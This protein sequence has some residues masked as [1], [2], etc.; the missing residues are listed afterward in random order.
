MIYTP[1]ISDEVLDDQSNRAFGPNQLE[2]PAL[3][4]GAACPTLTGSLNH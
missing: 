2:L 4:N 3:Q 1:N